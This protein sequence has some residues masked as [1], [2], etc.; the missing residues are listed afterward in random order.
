MCFGVL[1]EMFRNIRILSIDWIRKS[2]PASAFSNL[3]IYSLEILKVERT[4]QPGRPEFEISENILLELL[5][6][7]YSWKQISDML[8]VS[9]WTI[10]RRVVEY[11]LQEA[12]GYSTI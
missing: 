3:A 5:S 9:W 4:G 12:T 6:S 7:S 11:G 1:Q 8:L 10:R 2:E